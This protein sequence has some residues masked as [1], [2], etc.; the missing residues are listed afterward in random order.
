MIEAAG[1]SEKTVIFS[2]L[3]GA[4]NQK[5]AIF[6]VNQA[7]ISKNLVLDGHSLL[8]RQLNSINE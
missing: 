6:I 7:V 3:H 1:T 2:R 4:T 5:T 8:Y